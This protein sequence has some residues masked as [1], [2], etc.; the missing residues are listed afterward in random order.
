MKWMPPSNDQYAE[1]IYLAG[2]HVAAGTYR[3]VPDGR[4]ILLDKQD[5]LPATHDGRVA[6]YV[7]VRHLWSNGGIQTAV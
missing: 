4:E 2:E 3:Q 6:C 5:F 7:L 1:E